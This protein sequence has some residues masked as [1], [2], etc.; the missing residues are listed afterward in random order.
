MMSRN[1]I[2]QV[3]KLLLFITAMSAWEFSFKSFFSSPQ[4]LSSDAIPYY[5]HF[6]F[7]IK[8]VSKGIYPFWDNRSYLG[9]PNEFFL[10]RIGEFNPTYIFM[11]ILNKLGVDF[12]ITY[13]CFLSF[14]YL[15]GVCGFYKFSS[16]MFNNR[17]LAVIAFLLLMFSSLSSILSKSFIIIIFV[18]LV[19]FFYFLTDF[20]YSQKKASFFGMTFCL[21]I[22]LTTYVPF[23]FFTIL[24]FFVL[25]FIVF[26]YKESAR[27]ILK[28][29]KFV[30][31]NK[32]FVLSC[33]ILFFLS[34]LPGLMFFNDMKRGD[35]ILPVRHYLLESKNAFEVVQQSTV[36]GG[37]P[38][39]N[40]L[41]AFLLDPEYLMAGEVYVPIFTYILLFLAVFVRINKRLIFLFS[42]GF[43]VFLISI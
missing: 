1:Y 40:L 23:Y 4:M 41:G 33:A 13:S 15:L 36:V 17:L 9:M 19:W 18:P 28:A 26:Y 39:I 30:N 27:F 12:Y 3:F 16:K 7:F 22:V 24:V 25:F 34:S 11:L 32:F 10:R 8:S 20:Y 43:F 29:V 42:L 2:K 21:M 31:I 37:V 38:A 5:D 14:Y 35:L 6:E